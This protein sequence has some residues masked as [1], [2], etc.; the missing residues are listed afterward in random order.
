VNRLAPLAALLLALAACGDRQPVEPRMQAIRA[1]GWPSTVVDP[2]PDWNPAEHR[3]VARAQGGFVLLEEG[4]RGADHFASD[5][6]RESHFPRWI[7]REQFIFGPAWNS[8]RAPDGTVSL[9]TEGLTVVTISDGKPSRVRLAERGFRPQPFGDRILAE[10]GANLIEFDSR[11]EATVFAEGFDPVARR[12][13]VALA[14]R[15]SPAFTPDWWTGRSGA[16]AFHLRWKPGV[17]DIIPDGVQV[18]W[19]RDGGAVVTQRNAPAAPGDPW[20]SGGTRLLRLAAPGADA[21]VLVPGGRD[22]AANPVFDLLAWTGDDGG[23]WVGSLQPGGWRERI[24]EAGFRPRWSHDGLRV[25]WLSPPPAGSQLPGIR[26]TV[27]A[28]R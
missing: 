14:W 8:R 1:Y 16:A 12:D 15:D 11:G 5:D 25:C 19:T 3:L 2:E 7:N 4:G 22:P 27:L 20:W 23:V 9:P 13:G 6:R 28:V 10:E 18:A 17:I 21:A 26:V 24:A